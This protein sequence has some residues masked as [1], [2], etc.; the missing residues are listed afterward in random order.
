MGVWTR[1]ISLVLV[2]VLVVTSCA[3]PTADRYGQE[4]I[5]RVIET[6]TGRVVGFR[7]VGIRDGANS[8]LGALAAGGAGAGVGNLI[9][10]GGGS[11]LAM[12]ILGLVGAGLGYLA[13]EQARNREGFEY[14]IQT[15]DDQIITVVQNIDGNEEPLPIDT[16]VLLQFGTSYTRV[17]ELPGALVPPDGPDGDIWKNPDD[18]FDLLRPDPAAPAEGEP[19]S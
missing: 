9:G 17:L 15:D 12:V 18:F 14:I 19:T 8:G 10:S 7:D 16:P 4:D 3:F 11:I 2:I 13:E 1:R 6:T 5:G